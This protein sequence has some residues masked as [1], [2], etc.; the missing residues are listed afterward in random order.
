MSESDKNLK[1]EIIDLDEICEECKNFEKS[2]ISNFIMHG[3]K[4]CDSCKV[5][6]TIFPV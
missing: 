6:K 2:V 5:S 1:N 4:I 3:F